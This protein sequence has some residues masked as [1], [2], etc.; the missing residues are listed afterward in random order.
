MRTNQMDS[1]FREN[2]YMIAIQGLKTMG[3]ELFAQKNEDK[4]KQLRVAT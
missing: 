3:P 1:A 2:T 4:S